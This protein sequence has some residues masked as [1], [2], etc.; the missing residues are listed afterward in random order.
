M[1]G[2]GKKKERERGKLGMNKTR[3]GIQWLFIHIR[4]C[5][6]ISRY[7]NKVYRAILFFFLNWSYSSKTLI[8]ST[9]RYIYIYN[10]HNTEYNNYT[11]EISDM[12][13]YNTETDRSLFRLT[14]CGCR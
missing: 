1:E 4:C 12:R 10:T 7:S 5:K 3:A 6:I 2:G 11:A 13:R 8:K 9:S 14:K